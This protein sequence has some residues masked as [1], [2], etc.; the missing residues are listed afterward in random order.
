MAMAVRIGRGGIGRGWLALGLLGLGLACRGATPRAADGGHAPSPVA[1]APAPVAGSEPATAK[2][3]ADA[4]PPDLEPEDPRGFTPVDIDSVT[5][6]QQVTLP[7]AGRAALG[8]DALGLRDVYWAESYEH[9]LAITTTYYDQAELEAL[10]GPVAAAEENEGPTP[11]PQTHPSG[12]VTFAPGQVMRVIAPGKRASWPL[13]AFSA[14]LGASDGYLLAYFGKQ[15]RRVREALVLRRDQSHPGAALRA[16]RATPADATF[17]ATARGWIGSDPVAARVGPSHV[18]R[19]PIGA[20][21]GPGQLVAVSIML[22]VENSE[23]DYPGHWSALV[24]LD[25]KG[26]LHPVVPPQRR[27]HELRPAYL[28]DLAGDGI[29]A[30]VFHSS[31]VH[32]GYT[33]LAVWDGAAYRNLRLTGSGG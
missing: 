8:I 12:L 9:G 28:V 5:H 20:P 23:E 14:E 15:S 16:L 10:L 31:D 22:D 13:R 27:G 17:L 32:S 33:Y 30:I 3:A 25:S 29:D 7:E 18:S 19:A 11:P 21:G 4:Q 26:E 2:D 1:L 6:V 24:V